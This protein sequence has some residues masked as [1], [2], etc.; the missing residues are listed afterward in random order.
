MEYI[1][2][3]ELGHACWRNETQ[4]EGG[5]REKSENYEIEIQTFGSIC[6]SPI[7]SQLGCQND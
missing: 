7:P 1:S 6:G 5:L 4:K 3:M 2:E